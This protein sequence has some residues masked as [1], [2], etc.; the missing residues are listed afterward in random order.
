MA[1]TSLSW[2]ATVGVSVSASRSAQG[3]ASPLTL[4]APRTDASATA[5]HQIAFGTATAEGDIVCAKQD[6]LNP[7]AIATYDLYTG[8]DVLDLL[9]GAA[10]L[11]TL[12]GI[13]VVINS[14]GDAAG[15]RI[16]G[17]ASNAHPLFFAAA[18][19]MQLIAPGGPAFIQG[20]PTGVA[21]T[22]LLRNL[23]IENLGAVAV[24]YTVYLCGASV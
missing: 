22:T 9:A 8:A 16:G 7:G 20:T 5:E 17:A 2:K 21:I 14:G 13:V 12:R 11:R 10:P 18:N 3:N 1:L 24:T 23:K 4:P 15:V 19:D 6:K